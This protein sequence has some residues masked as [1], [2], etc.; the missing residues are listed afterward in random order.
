VLKKICAGVVELVG[1]DGTDKA[2]LVHVYLPSGMGYPYAYWPS[3]L[4]MNNGNE[5]FTDR[6][7]A[8]GIEP[9]RGGRFLKEKIGARPAARSSRCA[10]TADFDGDGRLDVVVNN[11]N[12][13]PF[14]FRNFFPRKNYVEFRL[15]GTKSN[16]DAIGAVVT[17]H[18]GDNRLPGAVS[19]D[20]DSFCACLRAVAGHRAER[21]SRLGLEGGDGGA[22]GGVALAGRL[23]GSC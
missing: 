9:P 14:Y 2:D 20:A 23:G 3:A 17:L 7:A 10:A 15:T 1:A 13:R 16:R 4:M 5:T 8:L 19:I 12:D 11:F 18:L 22:A 6:A 21:H